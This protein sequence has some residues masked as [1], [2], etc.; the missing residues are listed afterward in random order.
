[1]L[2]PC[3]FVATACGDD[4][5]DPKNLTTDLTIEQQQEAYATLRT[6]AAAALNNDG[7]KDQAYAMHYA[8]EVRDVV[9]LDNAG[10]T[11]ENRTLVESSARLDCADNITR[12]VYGG[13]KA[14]NTGYRNEI[15]KMFNSDGTNSSTEIDSEIVKYNGQY[16]ELYQNSDNDKAV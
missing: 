15:L 6:V 7:T 12:T 13:Y 10:L 4:P 3:M 2:A 11:A 9:N 16:Y 14:N 5:E 8:R 1:M